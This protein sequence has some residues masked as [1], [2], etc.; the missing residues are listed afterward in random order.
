MAARPTGKSVKLTVR[1]G[2]RFAKMLGGKFLR[3]EGNSYCITWP[4]RRDAMDE[5]A[6]FG[7]IMVAAITKAFE[8]ARSDYP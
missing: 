8:D 4:A 3:L 1:N 5:D 2:Q 7:P 6:W